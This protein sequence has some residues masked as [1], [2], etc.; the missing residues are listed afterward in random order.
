MHTVQGGTLAQPPAEKNATPPDHRSAAPADPP[1]PED[2]VLEAVPVGRRAAA[3]HCREIPY[4]EYKCDWYHGF[5]LYLRAMGISKASGGQADFLVSTLRQLARA[6]ESP[7]V[8][9]SGSVDYSMPSHALWAYEAEGAPQDLTLVDICETPLVLTRWYAERYGRSVSTVR[10][11]IL[12]YS[13]ERLYD[14][15]MT[16]SFLGSFAPEFRPRLFESWARV[17]R[18]GGK[19]I[20]TNRLRPTATGLNQF[21]EADTA[22]FCDEVM[23]EAATLPESLRQDLD[24]IAAS[25][26]AYCRRFVSHPLKTTEELERFLKEASFRI[27][28]LEVVHHGGRATGPV[29]GPS[30]NQRADY[31]RVIATRR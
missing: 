14:V 6:G 25:A 28:Q 17:L 15:A 13:P 23:R 22:V 20:F 21:S 10:S 5:W 9:I 12:E 2:P 3:T 1:P 7:R 18:P 29:S 16:N 30:I 31:A 26:R 19:L 4:E 11:D 24:W 27:D 8:L